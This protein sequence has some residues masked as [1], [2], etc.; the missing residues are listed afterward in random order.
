MSRMKSGRAERRGETG[1]GKIKKEEYIDNY[2]RKGAKHKPCEYRKYTDNE[3]IMMD[4]CYAIGWERVG[5]MP[6]EY[7]KDHP[8]RYEVH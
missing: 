8:E 2:G 7:C 4:M 6:C 5:D 3:G 1:M